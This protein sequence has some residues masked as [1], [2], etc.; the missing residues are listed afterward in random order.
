M[1]GIV[2]EDGPTR[3]HFELPDDFPAVVHLEVPKRRPPGGVL[4]AAV[5][6]PRLLEVAHAGVVQVVFIYP[7]R[8]G[9]LL[10]L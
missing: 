3:V 7:R 1:R 9:I 10:S 8:L 5:F 4:V 2:C 6:I